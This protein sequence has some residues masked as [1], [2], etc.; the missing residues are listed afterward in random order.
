ML[1]KTSS[2]ARALAV[3]ALLESSESI[4]YSPERIYSRAYQNGRE[5]GVSIWGFDDFHAYSIA[6]HRNSDQI[7]IYR[8]EQ[9]MQGL[10]DEAYR[11]SKCFDSVDAAAEWLIDAILADFEI[12]FAKREAHKT[13]AA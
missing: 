10:S 12:Q 1:T 8:G 5:Q 3:L 13:K 6:E 7:V 2:F 9:A 4:T 11:N